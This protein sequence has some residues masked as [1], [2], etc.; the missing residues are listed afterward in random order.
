MEKSEVK[1]LVDMVKE[2]SGDSVTLALGGYM[3]EKRPRRPRKARP[4]AWAFWQQP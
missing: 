1:P 3:A 2:A 4:R